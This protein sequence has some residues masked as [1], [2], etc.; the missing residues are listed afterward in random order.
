MNIFNKAVIITS[1]S[2]LAFTAQ[3]SVIIFD[4]N[5]GGAAKSGTVETATGS[6]TGNPD[7]WGLELEFTGFDVSGGISVNDNLNNG[8]FY[9]NNIIEA[10]ADQ[11]ITPGNGGLGVCAISTNCAGSTDSFQSNLSGAYSDEVMFFDFDVATILET[12]WFNGD[13]HENVDGYLTGSLSD[14]NDALF[15]IFYSSDGVL[16]EDVF[17]NQVQPTDLEFLTTGVDDGYKFWAISASGYGA[18]ASYVEAIEFSAV[19]EPSIVA[20]FGL[21]LLGLGLTRRKVVSA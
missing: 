10:F 3:A 11:D 14:G 1:I 20:L 8:N 21:G 2:F 13:H 15:N 16:Y 12:I 4:G 5:N 19:P 17:N 7:V 9:R 18:H 6:H